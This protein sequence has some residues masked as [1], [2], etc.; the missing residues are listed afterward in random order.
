MTHNYPERTTV[1]Q[2]FGFRK[3]TTFNFRKDTT[4]KWKLSLYSLLR[5]AFR[6]RSKEESEL[7]KEPV[8]KESAT[9]RAG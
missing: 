2:L 7:I 1:L 9:W 6:I 8:R 4:M 3:S 5:L